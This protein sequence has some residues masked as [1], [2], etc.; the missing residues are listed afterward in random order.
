MMKIAEFNAPALFKEEW[1]ATNGLGGFAAS[2]ILGGPTR[3]YHGLLVAAL[4]VPYGRTVMLNYAADALILPNRKE[5]PLSTLKTSAAGLFHE[6]PLIEFRL[7][8]GFPVWRYEIDG[9]ILEKT[10]FLVYR[11]NTVHVSYRLIQSATP[12]EIKWRPYLHFR[13]HDQLV[14]TSLNPNSYTVRQPKEA[15]FEIECLGFPALRLYHFRHTSF[16][17]DSTMIEDI[18]YELEYLQGY[19]HIGSLMS[20]GYYLAKLE[21]GEKT[22]FVASTQPWQA[23]QALPPDQAYQIERMRRRRM[24]KKDIATTPTAEKLILAADQFII[25]PTTR[26][27]DVIRQQA[28][29]EEVRTIIAGYPWFTDWGRDTMI[30]LEGLTLVTDRYREARAI[31][32]TFAYYIKDGLIPNMFPDG[33]AQGLYHTADATLWYFHAIDRYLTVTQD[34]S[35]LDFLLPKLLNIVES[36]IKGTIFGIH[37][38]KDG[39]LV[40]GKEGYQLTWMDAKVHDWV[41]TPRRGKAVEINALWYNALKL[42]ESWAGCC[43]TL[44]Q[45]CYDSFNRRFWYE[46]GGY[47]YDVVDGEGGDDPA[48][49][50]NQLFAISLRYPILEERHWKSVLDVVI[51]DLLTPVGLRTLSPDHPDFKPYYNGDIRARDGAYH[52]GTVWPWLLGPFID[53]WLKVYPTERDKARSF[54][55]GLEK[56]L[57][58]SCIESLCEIYDARQPF[59]RRGCFAQ[60]WSVAEFLRVFKLLE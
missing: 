55:Q 39:L 18:F 9:I 16:I 54:L 53:V 51:R 13:T 56:E 3:K 44:T 30:S 58:D 35:I 21:Y 2:T 36:H 11:Q 17:Q 42:L 15:H 6:V 29:G 34:H 12:L 14:S 40:Q 52:Q 26:S 23:I 57:D 50:P 10:L 60:A 7:D 1:L 37:A 38:D 33:A 47:L 48:L 31:L 4:P 46:K 32:E 49:R 24:L 5:I 28:A 8:Q 20:P 27:E 41:V 59:H 45:Q 19:D 25:T 22:T 43:F